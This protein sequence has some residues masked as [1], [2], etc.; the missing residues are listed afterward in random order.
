MS[1]VLGLSAGT[2]TS[3]TDVNA[4]GLGTVGGNPNTYVDHFEFR[5]SRFADDIVNMR[6]ME[7]PQLSADDIQLDIFGGVE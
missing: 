1:F 5:T 4:Y 2:I 3:A 6:N 7:I